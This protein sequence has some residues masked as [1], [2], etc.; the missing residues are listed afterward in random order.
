MLK[1]LDEYLDAALQRQGLR[2]DR[3]LGL[4]LGLTHSLVSQYRRAISWPS[5]EVMMALAELAGADPFIALAQLNV[6]RAKT[7]RA[8]DMYLEIARRA[9]GV[10]MALLIIQPI[11]PAYAGTGGEQINIAAA[12]PI[13]YATFS[14]TLRG[15]KRSASLSYS[16]LFRSALLT[17]SRLRGLLPFTPYR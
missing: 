16:A 1:T 4:A 7:A 15:A 17:L 10:I 14:L 3:S 8:R 9:A 6:W 2:S 12:R 5:D 13:H 11:L